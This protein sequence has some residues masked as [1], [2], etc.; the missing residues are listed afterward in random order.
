M[1]VKIFKSTSQAKIEEEI[2][3]WLTARLAAGNDIRWTQTAIAGHP[4]PTAG[5]SQALIVVSV[6]YEEAVEELD[7]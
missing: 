7:D 4:S 2:N 3:N 5:S 6:W 1:Q